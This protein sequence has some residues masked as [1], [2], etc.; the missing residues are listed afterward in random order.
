MLGLV[1]AACLLCGAPSAVAGTP[2]LPAASTTRHSIMLDGRSVAYSATAGALTLN[3]GAGARL[4]EMAYV[5]YAVEGAPGAERPITFVFG[6]GPG[7]SV[8]SLVLQMAGPR[9]LVEDGAVLPSTSPS[10]K[11]N[12]ESWLAFTDLVFVDPIGVGWSQSAL[13]RAATDRT[14]FGWKQDIEW[15]SRFVARWLA[16]AGRLHSPKYL[17]GES[18]GGFRVPQVAHRLQTEEG[19]GVAG[20]IMISPVIDYSLRLSRNGPLDWA[21]R[22][23]VMAAARIERDTGRD[24]DVN[25]LE[26]VFDYAFGDY[27]VDLMRPRT[28]QRA[29]KRLA[30][31]V[32]AITGLDPTL[33]RRM[34]GRIDPMTFNRELRRDK[35]QV[36]SRYDASVL[37]FDPYSESS[38]QNWDDPG[39]QSVAPIAT[40]MTAYAMGELGWQPPAPYRYADRTISKQRWE[41]PYG[42]VDATDDLRRALAL[43]PKL[44]LLVAHGATDFVTP[45]LAT[46]I[47]LDQL[48]PALV[49]GR[50]DVRL[51]AGGHGFY[52]RPASR[53]ALLRDVRA[54]Y[55][56]VRTSPA[57]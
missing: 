51:Y 49:A 20:M 1:A 7:Y 34:T 21:T 39:A 42:R 23:P 44:K 18:Y 54:L 8:G 37:A 11:D 27:L 52:E 30:A 35:G 16:Q 50:I 29:Q 33:V 43:D 45:Y 19:I 10:L 5:A 24:V 25:L 2:P 12:P 6:G 4:G 38:E 26:P 28:D 47:I 32:S 48:P 22:L 17:A 57:D 3:D 53:A 15:L 9:R 46:R 31:K 13:D 14:F 55:A 56:P 36:G 40:A 41:W